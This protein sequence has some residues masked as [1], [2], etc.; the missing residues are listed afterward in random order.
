M[1]V[2]LLCLFWSS[3]SALMLL[4]GSSDLETHC[5]RNDLNCVLIGTLNLTQLNSN[6]CEFDP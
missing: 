5:L 3:F 4:V 6:A 2:C 1:Y